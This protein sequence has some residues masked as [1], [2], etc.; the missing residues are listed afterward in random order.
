MSRSLQFTRRELNAGDDDAVETLSIVRLDGR[1]S[2]GRV[3][4][5]AVQ[6]DAGTPDAPGEFVGIFDLDGDRIDANA[7]WE[8]VPG[9]RIPAGEEALRVAEELAAAANLA[10]CG[11]DLTAADYLEPNG[12]LTF[13]EVLEDWASGDRVVE[14]WLVAH[15]GGRFGLTAS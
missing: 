3:G 4:S 7:S 9:D 10:T 14:P 11:S 8:L 2:S 13:A 1:I 15:G 6:V 5:F 12:S